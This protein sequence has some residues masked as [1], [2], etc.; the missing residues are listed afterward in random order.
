MSKRYRKGEKFERVIVL[1]SGFVAYALAFFWAESRIPPDNVSIPLQWVAVL[2]GAVE[3]LVVM[4][5]AVQVLEAIHN[6]RQWRKT[7]RRW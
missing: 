3:G 2:F 6:R 5:L 7:R 1:L 4:L